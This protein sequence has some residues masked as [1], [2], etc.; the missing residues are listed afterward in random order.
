MIPE[1]FLVCALSLT[2]V[3]FYTTTPQHILIL[4]IESIKDFVNRIHPG[5]EVQIV[6]EENKPTD[7][8]WERLPFTWRGFSIYIKRHHI[9]DQSA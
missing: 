1:A 5:A 2:A 9:F 4:E 3:N 7:P 6:Q 8:H